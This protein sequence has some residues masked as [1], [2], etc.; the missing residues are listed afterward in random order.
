MNNEQFAAILA[1]TDASAAF[2]MG[3]LV[4]HGVI[5]VAEMDARLDHAIAESKNANN[6]ALLGS[7]FQSMKAL[8]SQHVP[9]PQLH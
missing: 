6:G 7:V 9:A 4:D 5:S 3:I 1:R 8:L 2:L